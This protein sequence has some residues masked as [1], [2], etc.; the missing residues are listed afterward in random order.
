[1]ATWHKFVCN[2]CNALR[3]VRVCL[4]FNRFVSEVAIHKKPGTPKLGSPLYTHTHLCVR[5]QGAAS[6]K[7]GSHFVKSSAP[8]R[9]STMLSN[10]I[11]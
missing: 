5:Q 4:C 9:T 1:M 10:A 11:K 3:L 7:P 2:H 8:A 6:N